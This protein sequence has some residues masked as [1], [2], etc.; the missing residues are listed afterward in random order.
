VFANALKVNTTLAELDLSGTWK[1]RGVYR[2][3]FWIENK[4]SQPI[5]DEIKKL[6]QAPGRT[7][8]SVRTTTPHSFS[9]SLTCHA[10]RA[11][12]QRGRKQRTR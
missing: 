7:P 9:H 4:V 8:N 2:S 1:K 12:S 6:L 11:S 5:L 3:N 10:D